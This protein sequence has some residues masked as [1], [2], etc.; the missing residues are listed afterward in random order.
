MSC[1]YVVAT[2]IGNM[3][4]ISI[5]AINTLKQ[6]DLILTPTTPTLPFSIGAKIDDPVEMYLSDL[7]TVSANLTGLPAIS[8]PVGKEGK[9]PVGMQ[10]IGPAFSERFLTEVGN[11]LEWFK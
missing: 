11:C 3:E 9:Y 5:H 6:V 4:D 2:P 7:L 8:I 10:L 1:L